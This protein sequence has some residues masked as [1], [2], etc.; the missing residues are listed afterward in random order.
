LGY[1][2]SGRKREKEKREEHIIVL[3][4]PYAAGVGKPPKKY[5]Y[6]VLFTLYG[7]PKTG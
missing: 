5:G 7:R 6:G 3:L 1:S 4:Q 2:T